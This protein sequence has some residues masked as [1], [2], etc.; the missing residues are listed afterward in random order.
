MFPFY[1]SVLS[2]IRI[3]SP[4]SKFYFSWLSSF[5]WAAIAAGMSLCNLG[6]DLTTAWIEVERAKSYKEWTQHTKDISS[7]FFLSLHEHSDYMSVKWNQWRTEGGEYSLHPR[8]SSAR[9]FIEFVKN[10]IKD[11]QYVVVTWKMRINKILKNRNLFQTNKQKTMS[12]NN[13]KKRRKNKPKP[14]KSRRP[15]RTQPPKQK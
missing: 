12:V 15:G 8:S 5:H 9:S 7:M 11:R 13:L 3:L 4:K 1:L 6:V 10:P 2:S 14:K